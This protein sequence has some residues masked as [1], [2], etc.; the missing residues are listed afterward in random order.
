[1]KYMGGK[2]F[3]SREISD[4]MKE[5]VKSED[6]DGYLEPFCGAL[7]VLIKMNEDFDCVASDYHPDLIQLW[8]DIQE[9]KFIPPTE[10][11]EII[12]NESKNLQSPSAM[13]GFIGFGMSFGGKF[14]AGYSEKYKNSKK[15]NYLQE[16]INSIKKIK[17]KINSVEFKCLSYEK[18]NPKNKLIYCDPPYQTTKFPIKYRTDTKIY[19]KFDNEKFWDIMRKW[20][21][22]NYVF[23]SETTAPD[24]FV[25]IW[26]KKTHRSAS[27]SDKTRYKN[28]S[29]SFKIE[30]LFI[31]NKGLVINILNN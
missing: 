5:I 17:P 1:M 23:I 7:N 10:M 4:T 13:K 21:Q 6:I 18:H 28:P 3:L 31:Y 26:E 30:K 24:D 16:A 12:Y 27:Q 14:Y 15:E 9:D 19:D 22:T 11:D 8:K 20:S 29:E 2:Y 25:P